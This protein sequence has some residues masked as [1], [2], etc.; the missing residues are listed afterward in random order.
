MEAFWQVW[1]M[2]DR[3]LLSLE[4]LNNYLATDLSLYCRFGTLTQFQITVMPNQ[5]TLH[6]SRY[7][8]KHMFK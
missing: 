1:V 8:I 6:H 3:H 2:T 5:K 4:D 7:A